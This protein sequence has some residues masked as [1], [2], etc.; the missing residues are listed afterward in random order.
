[1]KDF[2]VVANWKANPQPWE[3]SEE[4]P[5]T[6]VIAG[7]YIDLLKIKDQRSKI[8]NITQNLKLFIASQN[9]SK[10]SNGPYTGEVTAEMIKGLAD[11]CLIGHSERRRLFAET[12]E[13]INEKIKRCRE[14]RIT[15]IVFARNE[16][17]LEGLEG[18]EGKEGGLLCYEPEEG[19]SKNGIFQPVNYEAIKQTLNKWQQKYNG[20]LLYGGSVNPDNMEKIRKT[21]GELL[22]GIVVGQASLNKDSFISIINKC[23]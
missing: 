18:L 2:L 13:E 16:G 6:V 23:H 7:G 20:K 8:K 21:C 5:V 3:I 14:V 1:M 10:Y 9:I 17:D 15:P 4:F 22:S 11:Y 12:N 19:I